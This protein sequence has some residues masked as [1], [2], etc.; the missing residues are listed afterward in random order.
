VRMSADGKT[1]DDLRVAI[2]AAAEVPQRFPEVE[3][4]AR[5]TDLGEEVARAVADGYAQRIDTLADMRGSAW[6]R[7]EMIRVWVRR[8]IE[9]A[10]DGGVKVA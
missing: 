2:G 10:R 5:G 8:A 6:Y 1:C 7:T 3:A 9:R 4:T